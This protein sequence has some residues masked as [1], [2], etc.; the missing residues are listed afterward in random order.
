[1]THLPMPY[2][3]LLDR[4]LQF[5]KHCCTLKMRNRIW[6]AVCRYKFSAFE[7]QLYELISDHD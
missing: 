2:D 4:D 3:P 6:W 5:E 7:K 1:M